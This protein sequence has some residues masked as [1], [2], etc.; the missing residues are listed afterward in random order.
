M[1]SSPITGWLFPGQGS[2]YLG[3]GRDL[4][5]RA[6]RP[7]EIVEE[8]E[9]VSGFPL[10]QLSLQG[11]SDELTRTDVLQ[12]ALTAISLG[13][14]HLLREAGFQPD[15]VAGHS[16][17]EFAALC[18]AGVFGVSECLRLVTER[19]RLMQNVAQHLDGGMGAVKRVTPEQL[20]EVVAAHA[21]GVSIANWNSPDQI[22]VSGPNAALALLGPPI[23]TAGGEFIP[24]PVAGPWHHPS[25]EEAAAAFRQVVTETTFLAP[26][27]P[28][29][30]NV[31]AAGEA[32]PL[33][34]KGLVKLQMT[35]PVLWQASIEAMFAAGAG[36]FLEVGPGKVLR[37]LM[38][39]IIPDESTYRM[40]GIENQRSLQ[41]LKTETPVSC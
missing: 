24:L 34:I 8:A 16:L 21:P 25:M 10:R 32:D 1:V 27:C 39:R 29:F 15:M 9:H 17:G 33:Q 26:R 38:R 5:A 12:P 28:V 4:W 41:F 22:V 18:A 23:T 40:R 30:M 36:L 20:A 2:Q 31:S 37:G 6:G 35:S 14:V 3:M 11:P 13:C 7:L 19:S